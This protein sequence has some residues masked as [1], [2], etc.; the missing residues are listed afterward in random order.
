MFTIKHILNN[1]EFLHSGERV[2]FYSNGEEVALYPE[3]NI[4]FK[5]MVTVLD[6]DGKVL[7]TLNNGR[8][9]VMNNH[10]STVAKYD[11]SDLE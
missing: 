8:V 11:M 6:H 9:Y 5:Q 4:P 1:I 7:N 3:K 10:G 2:V